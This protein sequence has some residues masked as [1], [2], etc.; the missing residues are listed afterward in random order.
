MSKVLQIFNGKV[1][2]GKLKLESADKDKLELWLAML[3]GKEI[4]LTI[5]ERKEFRSPESN[6][7]YWKC[8]IEPIAE[9]FGWERDKAHDFLKTRYN[10]ELFHWKEKEIWITKSTASLKTDEFSQY[11]ERCKTF[12]GQEGIVLPEENEVQL[13]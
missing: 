7:Y 4:G 1:N 12:A 6:R 8:V 5:G 2:S 13:S 9:H 3:E 11:L 10:S